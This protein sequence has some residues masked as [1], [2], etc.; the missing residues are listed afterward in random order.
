MAS[1]D[2]RPS[3]RGAWRKAGYAALAVLAVLVLALCVC[4]AVEWPFL[5]HPL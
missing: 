2:P 4:E 5:R 1:P 3:S